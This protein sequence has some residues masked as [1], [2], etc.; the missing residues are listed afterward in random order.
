MRAVPGIL[1][2][3][4]RVA[5]VRK[6]RRHDTGLGVTGEDRAGRSGEAGSWQRRERRL[7]A[8]TSH[9]LGN[10]GKR[11]EYAFLITGPEPVIVTIQQA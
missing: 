2:A 3:G 8:S 6:A 5:A 10:R 4:L 9:G 11:I 7:P 1:G